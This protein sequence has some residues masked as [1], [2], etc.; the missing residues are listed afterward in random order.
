MNNSKILLGGN[1]MYYEA[2]IYRNNV[3]KNR[4]IANS[5]DVL[6]SKARPYIEDEK[7]EKIVVRKVEEIGYFKVQKEFEE[8]LEEWML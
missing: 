5:I 2:E 1:D 8:V 4:F 7:V 3:V 6:K